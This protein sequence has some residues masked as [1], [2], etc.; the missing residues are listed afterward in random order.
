MHA[1]NSES[2][3]RRRL[4]R[5]G[6]RLEKAPARHWT[7]RYGAGYIVADDRNMAVLGVT[8]RPYEATLQDVATFTERL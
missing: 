7:R 5:A 8:H 2:A 1:C 3:I 4:A 6:Y